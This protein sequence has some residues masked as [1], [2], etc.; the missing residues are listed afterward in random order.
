M[1]N[2]EQ[3]IN[4]ILNS[5]GIPKDKVVPA[6]LEKLDSILSSLD[7][8]SYDSGYEAG[9]NDGYADGYADAKAETEEEL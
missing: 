8:D 4:E 6:V 2:F 9:S 5:L 1:Y 3:E 7:T